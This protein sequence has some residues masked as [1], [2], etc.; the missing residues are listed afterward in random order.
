MILI[1]DLEEGLNSFLKPRV[2]LLG[3]CQYSVR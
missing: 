2:M 1:L 3:S